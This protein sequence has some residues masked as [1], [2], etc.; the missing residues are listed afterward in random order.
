MVDGSKRGA[1]FQLTSVQPLWQE[2]E[3]T[4]PGTL[5]SECLAARCLGVLSLLYGFEKGMTLVVVISFSD[6]G[7]LFGVVF[8]DGTVPRSPT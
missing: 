1:G 8:Y 6:W 4:D 2:P 3:D 5:S 7:L